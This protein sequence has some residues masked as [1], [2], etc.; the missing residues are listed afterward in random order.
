[1][2]TVL[3]AELVMLFLVVV[4]GGGAGMTVPGGMVTMV[5]TLLFDAHCPAYVSGYLGT[6][7]DVPK[8]KPK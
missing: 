1:M 4:V 2:L 3:V 5:S 6:Y 7:A 8:E